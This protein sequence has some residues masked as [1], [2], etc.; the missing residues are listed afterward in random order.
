[1]RYAAVF[2]GQGSQFEGMADPWVAHPAGVA[3]LEEASEAL[4]RDVIEGCHDP[5]ALAT[6]AFVQPALLACDV[7]AFRVLEDEG[8]SF[9]G[10]AGHSLGEFAALVA[11]DAT[12]LPEALGAVV[13]RG[14]AM[15][16]AGEERPGTMTALLGMG[17][18]DANALCD[19]ARGDDVLLVA[20]ENSPAQVVIS[21]NVAA[22]ERAEQLAKARKMRAIRLKVAGA[23]HSPLMASAVEP[24]VR[25]LRRIDIRA[26]RFP[27]AENV[28]GTLVTDPDELRALLERHVVSPVRWE[29][30]AQALA[31]RRRRRRSSRR[32]P[33]TCSRSSPSASRS[34]RATAPESPPGSAEPS[35]RPTSALARAPGRRPWPRRYPRRVTRHSAIT[36][37]GSHLPPRLVPNA[38]SNPSLRPTING[39]VTGRASRRAISPTKASMTSDIAVD[40]AREALETAA[41][42]PEQLDLIVCASMTGDTVFPSTA[43]WVQQKLGVSCPA[44]DVN[45]ACAGFSYGLSTASALR[46][47]RDG[48]H[49][50]ADRR[51]DL[52]PHHRPD[53]SGHVRALR[54]RRGRDRRAGVRHA[55][56]RGPRARRRRARGGDPV[57]AGGRDP[58]AGHARDRRRER[59]QAAHAQRTRGVQARRHRDVRRVPRAA[60]EIR[61]CR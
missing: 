39:S 34:R 46:H 47:E 23:F 7:A 8:V 1:M 9:V 27:I 36:G 14:E 3:V 10:V 29:A 33:A 30:C 58:H 11:A 60:R 54:R 12:S 2:P 61:T 50:P 49:R 52:Q 19:E 55:G 16:R 56:H 59:A 40:A 48:G 41:V 6:T 21:G 53:R 26:P 17:T 24:I 5:E 32:V 43:V 28:S 13:V 20:N 31:V 22:I 44:F 25:E 37:V 38:G 35:R 15:Q 18:D 51:G 4:G 57:D 42:P 45:A